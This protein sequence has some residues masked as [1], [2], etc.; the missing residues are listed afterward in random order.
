MK[1]LLTMAAA[2]ALVGAGLVAGGSAP[3][4]AQP[5]ASSPAAGAV[6]TTT[7]QPFSW[8]DTGVEAGTRKYYLEISTLPNVAAFNYGEF[9]GPLVFAQGDITTTS[10]NLATIGRALSPG[11]YYW[12]VSGTYGPYGIN[13]T[14]WSA[15]RSFV[16]QAAT[17]AAPAIGLSPTSIELTVPRGQPLNTFTEYLPQVSLSNLGSGTITITATPSGVQWLSTAAGTNDGSIQKIRVGVSGNVTGL[18]QLPVG[19]YSSY[20]RM[21][22]PGAVTRDLI[23][24]MRVVAADSTPPVV[25]TIDA[26]DVTRTRTITISPSVTDSGSGMGEMQ[27][28]NDNEPMSDWVP[29]ATT[30]RWTLPNSDGVH[31][32]WA[33]FRDRLGNETAFFSGP[34]TL[35]TTSPTAPTLTA[36]TIVTG[37]TRTIALSWTAATDPAP[38]SGFVGY[39]VSYRKLPSSTWIAW[40]GSRTGLSATFT[41]LAGNTYEFRVQSVD[42]AGGLST[43][44]TIR[45]TVVPYDQSAATYAGSWSTVTNS[46][47]YLGSWRRSTRANA[48][49]SLTT[50]ARSIGVLVTKGPGH[51]GA[52]IYVDG[53]IAMVINTQASSTVYRKYIPVETFATAGTHTVKVVNLGTA[54]RSTVELDGIVMGR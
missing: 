3:A 8:T 34:I 2:V 4:Q 23:V 9:M 43:P 25:A 39:R 46:N 50:V 42:A 52:A 36:P 20:V 54:G 40:G 53:A 32:L 29:Y 31:T 27:F 30:Q 18:G 51:G 11:T 38:S 17:A 19:T 10:L 44:S 35:D 49:A 24:T 13:G 1:R 5:V 14:S 47:A 12:H 22:A 41:G 48:S 37:K 26:P 21:T 7:N 28:G 33:K 6:L 16:V 15:V 45:K